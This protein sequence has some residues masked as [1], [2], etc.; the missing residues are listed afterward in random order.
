VS[1]GLVPDEVS[2]RPKVAI[3]TIGW[4]RGGFDPLVRRSLFASE[5][6]HANPPLRVNADDGVNSV[7]ATGYRR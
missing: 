6:E 5:V 2:S 1:S 4:K 7:V 3:F